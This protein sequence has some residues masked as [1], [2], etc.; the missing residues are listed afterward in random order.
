MT[1]QKILV[2][3]FSSIGDVVLTAPA[4]HAL[5]EQ[6]PAAEI[7]LLTKKAVAPVWKGDERVNVRFFDPDDRHFGLPGFFRFL[8][9]LRAEKYDVVV[10][11]HGLPKVRALTFA[12]GR[13]ALHYDKASMARRRYVKTK[14]PP[15]EIVHSARR[16][17]R[18]LAPLG[19][20]PEQPLVPAIGVDERAAKHVGS[21]VGPVGIK[22][23]MLVGI[24]PGSQ[25]FTKQWGWEN[26]DA[27]VRR[28]SDQGQWVA[29]VG[30]KDERDRCEQLAQGRKALNFAGLLNLQETLALMDFC[31]LFVSNDSGPMHMAGA[32]GADVIALFGSTTKELGFWPLAPRSAILEVQGLACRPCDPHGRAACPEGHFRCMRE[33][34]VDRVW[35]EIQTFLGPPPQS[36]PPAGG[37]DDEG[38]FHFGND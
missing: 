16:Y 7:H 22:G 18:A 15:A 27:I 5:H 32:R 36:P 14:R 21:L 17:V 10:D 34:S 20:D 37:S 13:P 24:A 23:R 3:R 4:I 38:L 35:S 30:G 31:R 28:L 26:F 25:W 33:L 8:A 1:P 6:F 2:I 19:I 12:L 29:L 9:E 11:L